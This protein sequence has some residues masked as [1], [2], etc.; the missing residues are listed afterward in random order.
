MKISDDHKN[1]CKYGLKKVAYEEISR[2][3]P[4]VGNILRAGVQVRNI[5][6]V[7][8]TNKV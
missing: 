8:S 5:R 4:T 7:G 2:I 6:H 1:E 3:S